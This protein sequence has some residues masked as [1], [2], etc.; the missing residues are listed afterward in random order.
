MKYI[1]EELQRLNKNYIKFYDNFRI[2]NLLIVLFTMYAIIFNFRDYI[3]IVYAFFIML[4]IVFYAEY[5]H[6]RLMYIVA[7]LFGVL[8]GMFLSGKPPIQLVLIYIGMVIIFTVLDFY[9]V[10]KEEKSL[11]KYL[12][13]L[14]ESLLQIYIISSILMSGLTLLFLLTDYMIFNSK[15]TD[16]IY[17]CYYLCFGIYLLPSLILSVVYNDNKITKLSDILISKVLMIIMNVYFGIVLL[18][19][20]KG[21][22]TMKYS[23]YSVYLIIGCLFLMFLPL[24]IMADNYKGK[25]YEINSKYLKYVFIVPLIL[26]IYVLLKQLNAYGF[27]IPRYIGL[28]FV[29]FEIFSLGLLMYKDKKYIVDSL[30]IFCV[31]TFVMFVI[32]GCNVRDAVLKSQIARLTEIYTPNK[33]FNSL[34]I[35]DKKRVKNIYEYIDDLDDKS[36]YEIPDYIDKDEIE[37][38]SSYDISGKFDDSFYGT[39]QNTKIDIKN[40]KYMESVLGSG[41]ENI[42]LKDDLKYNFR[43]YGEAALNKSEN[44]YNKY[45]EE[46]AL[47]HVNDNVDFYITYI[48]GSVKNDEYSFE[49]VSGYLLYK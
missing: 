34:S 14:F 33:T 13:N 48:N 49:D 23:I 20:L 45:L 7:L 44:E 40:Y 22:F 18:Y 8:S 39:N 42:T 21:L 3:F 5:S 25:Y 38:F 4:P 19:T 16:Y 10:I 27:T 6:R 26:Q 9:I 43:S 29:I 32:P 31:L 1:K 28:M 41:G 24:S 35:N 12:C 17:V 46:H 11:P 47:V 36:K 30:L 15:L 37:K 2:T